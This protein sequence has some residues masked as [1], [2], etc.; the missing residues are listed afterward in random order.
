MNQNDPFGLFTDDSRTVVIPKPGGRGPAGPVVRRAVDAPGMGPTTS[1]IPTVGRN[2]LVAA[3]VGILGLA[4][5][6]RTASPPAEV[7]QLRERLITELR[8]FEARAEAGGADRR[9]VQLAAWALCALIDDVVLNTPW[10]QHSVWPTQGLV[11][12]LFHEVDAGERFFERL[13]ELERDAGRYRDL[14]ELMYL[15]LTLGFEGRFRVQRGS[16]HGLADVRDNLYRLLR[17]RTPE[18]EAE[19]SPHWRGVAAPLERDRI[20]VPYWVIGVG[21]LA[22]LLVVY[23]GFS[24]RLAAYT[25]QVGPLLQAL[26][27]QAEVSI[28]RGSAVA[29]AAAVA[30]PRLA[31]SV[32][33][34]IEALLPDE[35][36]DGRLV[37]TEDAQRVTVRL[38]GGVFGS[39][40][41]AVS[42]EYLPILEQLGVALSDE[43]G[44]VLV[45][46]H[47]DSIPIRTPRFP[48]NWE[49]SQ[50][51][52][53][54]V[55]EVLAAHLSGSAGLATDGRADTE[56]LAP[57]DTAEGRDVNRRI[58]IILVKET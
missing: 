5:R 23:A 51:R 25:E 50:A 10:G 48:S 18:P 4:P 43:P 58:E 1:M 57:N 55:A 21:T 46:G 6:L 56:P 32:V 44:Q 14:L 40:K 53:L 52:A 34:K 47:T 17:Q 15:C 35:V 30:D 26:P 33:E 8:Q 27:P 12:T 19:L 38:H 13:A 37:A 39:G 41:A 42:P 45:V 36:A 2:P 49:L 22:V 11:A 20:T 7:E 54:A 16:G 24:F 9:S 31:Y 3:A 29:S 28:D